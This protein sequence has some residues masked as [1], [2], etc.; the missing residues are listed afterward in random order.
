MRT[1][2]PRGLLAADRAQ[3]LQRLGRRRTARPRSR[4]RCARREDRRASR[5]GGR[6]AADR[7]RP[8]RPAPA[9]GDRGRPR[10]S[11]SRTAAPWPRRDRRPPGWRAAAAGPSARCPGEGRS[12]TGRPG[13]ARRRFSPW[14]RLRRPAKPS[15]VTS[16]AVTSSQSA[17]S[18][19]MRSRR[20]RGGD[21]VHEGRARA[22]AGAP[23]RRARA[24]TAG[25]ATLRR[26][27]SA[28]GGAGRGAR[29][30]ARSRRSSSATGTVADRRRPAWRALSCSPS[31]PHATSPERQS[32]SSQ[33]GW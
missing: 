2:W 22:L 15:P 5:A 6:R 23:A 19:S 26:E 16:P 30:Q 11:A 9:A 21:V 29:S 18:T 17:S 8:A 27:S 7:A 4:P 32:S 24:R 20:T 1:V 33:P 28:S 12:A 25:S 13:R 3:R 10:R 31:R 14:S